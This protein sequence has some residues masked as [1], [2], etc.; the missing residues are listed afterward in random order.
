MCSWKVLLSTWD[1]SPFIL[2]V[3]FRNSC[4][5][6][7]QFAFTENL[8]KKKLLLFPGYFP[9]DMSKKKKIVTTASVE[10]FSCLQYFTDLI[11]RYFNS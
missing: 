2:G 9:G 1:C 4:L 5:K 7:C 3:S 6:Q 8:T 11:Q 10:M